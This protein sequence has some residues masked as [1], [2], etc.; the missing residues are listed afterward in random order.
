MRQIQPD[1]WETDT[2]S[3]APGLTTHAYLVTKPGGNLLFYNTSHKHEI[4][5]MERIGGVSHQFL[6][7]RDELGATLKDIRST[8][9]AKLCGHLHEEEDFAKI[10]RPDI[11]FDRR[12]TLLDNVEVIPTPGHSPGSTCFLVHSPLGKRYLFTGDTL[13]RAADGSW[14]AGVIPGY[15]T[16]ED[17]LLMAESIKLL[18]PLEPDIVFSSAF[19]GDKG[20]QEVGR[21]EW[22]QLVEGALGSMGI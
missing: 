12:T 7:H 8:Y 13:Y 9:G 17:K 4:D 1:V 11:L 10:L 19:A 14:R 22:R 6:S 15:T 18:Q 21:D 2:E 20:Y 3:P 16:E 5:D